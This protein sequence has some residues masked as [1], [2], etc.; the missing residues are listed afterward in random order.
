MKL[1]VSLCVENGE[2]DEP[3]S[4][5]EGPGDGEAGH[6]FFARTHIRE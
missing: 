3:A 5:D 2:K 4:A 6:D 1:D